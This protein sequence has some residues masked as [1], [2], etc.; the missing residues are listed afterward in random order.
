MPHYELLF[1]AHNEFVQIL[2]DI[3][4]QSSEHSQAA[5]KGILHDLRK[6]EGGREE[7]G[8]STRMYKESDKEGKKG[9]QQTTNT[10]R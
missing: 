6:R 1:R 10:E 9:V 8:E 3:L 5:L 4:V 7:G 2:L